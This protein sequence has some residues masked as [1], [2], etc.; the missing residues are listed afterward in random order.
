[1]SSGK[2]RAELID[3]LLKSD[4]PSIRWK[5]LTGVLGEDSGSRK[6]KD[7]R[8]EIR[9]SRRA[10]AIL[11]GRDKHYVREPYVYANW[12]GAHWTLS[13][14]A[15]LGYPEIDGELWFGIFAPAKTAPETVD[16]LATLYT[17]ALQTGEVQ[18]KIT[19]LGLRPAPI[20]GSRFA[21]LLRKQFERY[22]SVV[23]SAGANRD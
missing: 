9:E 8:D 18:E 16:R 13:M 7:L 4:E 10:Q 6:I 15:E 3:T 14:L 19:N 1:M 21:N 17:N 2:N 22:G 11:A 5:V 23:R 12:R 20:C